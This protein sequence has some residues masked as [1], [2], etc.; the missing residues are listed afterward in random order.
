MGQQGMDP[1]DDDYATSR[2]DRARASPTRLLRRRR[3]SNA[4]RLWR[5]LHAALPRRAADGLPQLLVPDFYERLGSAERR[6]YLTSVA[7]DPSQLPPRGQRFVR[8]YR[9]EFGEQ[10]DPLRRLRARGD[11]AAARRDRPRRRRA[12]T[13]RERVVEADCFDTTNFDSVVGTFSID[14]NGDTSLDAGRR[15]PRARRPARV[16]QAAA[17][18]SAAG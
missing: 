6:T 5:D 3:E 17:R 11:V 14:D 18:R 1:R 8:D 9:R 13:E 16:R 12:P 4:V 10:P 2:G 7:Q 15:L